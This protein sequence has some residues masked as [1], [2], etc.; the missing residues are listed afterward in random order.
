MHQYLCS[1]ISCVHPSHHVPHP[2]LSLHS[3]VHPSTA[4]HS[5]FHMP[6]A[7]KFICPSN[8]IVSFLHTRRLVCNHFSVHVWN[9][10]SP[11]LLHSL[12][13][14]TLQTSAGSSAYPITHLSATVSFSH[15]LLRRSFASQ[16]KQESGRPSVYQ[17]P[18]YHGPHH[19][20]SLLPALSSA[21]FL[22]LPLPK[23]CNYSLCGKTW[24]WASICLF[25]WSLIHLTLAVCGGLTQSLIENRCSWNMC[26]EASGVWVH[27]HDIL[28]SVSSLMFNQTCSLTKIIIIRNNN[29]A[30]YK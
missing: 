2:Y 23:A 18:V 17:G 29:N 16:M 25:P 19:T 8:R 5:S 28:R 10:R 4:A 21:A 12:Y 30:A 14:R 27:Q 9:D 6:L 3:Q 22:L 24:V 13:K 7:Y 20:I 15:F 11:F 1:S 26:G